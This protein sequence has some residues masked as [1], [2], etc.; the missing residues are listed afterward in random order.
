MLCTD[1]LFLH[2]TKGR[3][4]PLFGT[5]KHLFFFPSGLLPEFVAAAASEN[6][7][8]F[9]INRRSPTNERG[10]NDVLERAPGGFDASHCE[11][12]RQTE[13]FDSRQF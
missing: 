7:G 1:S 11:R 9:S 3:C 6:S 12:S 10:R 8:I 4:V 5:G 2:R 13:I